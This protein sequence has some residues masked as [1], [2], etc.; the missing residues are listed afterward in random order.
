MVAVEEAACLPT[1]GW[2][3]IRW[4][5]SLRQLCI[6]DAL[7]FCR[8]A[9][10]RA[11]LGWTCHDY[12]DTLLAGAQGQATTHRD[13]QKAKSLLEESLSISTELGMRPL[14]ERVVALQERSETRQ[15]RGP[16]YPEDLV[17]L[18]DSARAP[19]LPIRFGHQRFV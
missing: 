3:P 9:G 12:A 17:H 18:I 13:H 2:D 7:T 5:P 6:E 1:S 16:V 19:R 14:M 8:K 11:E 4:T 15:V 10:Y